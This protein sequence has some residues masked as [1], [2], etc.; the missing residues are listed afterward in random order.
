MVEIDARGGR[1]LIRRDEQDEESLALGKSAAESLTAALE[2]II[3]RLVDLY[4][5]QNALPD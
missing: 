2:P 5:V 4:N 3:G 1:L